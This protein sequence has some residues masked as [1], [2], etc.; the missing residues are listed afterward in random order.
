MSK[1]GLELNQVKLDDFLKNNR[2]N[3]KIFTADSLIN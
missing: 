1:E 3:P 2:I